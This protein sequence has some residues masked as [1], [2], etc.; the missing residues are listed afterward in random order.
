MKWFRNIFLRSPSPP[1][2]LFW[3]DELWR[4]AT[5]SNG[6]KALIQLRE[7]HVKAL[8]KE[9]PT[10]FTLNTEYSGTISHAPDS[11]LSRLRVDLVVETREMPF[12][13][14]QALP[15]SVGVAYT[16][17]YEHG[18]Q[19]YPLLSV[20]IWTDSVGAT[21]F[22]RSFER[23]IASGHDCV[24]MWISSDDRA[25]RMIDSLRYEVVQPLFSIAFDQ[26][27][28]LRQP[29]RARRNPSPARQILG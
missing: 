13:K 6:F 1:S 21:A 12:G 28:A 17:H 27:L 22:E 25:E 11:N 14:D 9:T 16:G 18:N 23:A 19:A 15:G 4:E 8:W 3:S 5:G 26:S 7:M 24:P 2:V 20:R 29:Q 10:K